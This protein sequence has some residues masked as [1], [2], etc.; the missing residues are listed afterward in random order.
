MS[1]EFLQARPQL[2]CSLYSIIARN[3]RYEDSMMLASE[4]SALSPAWRESTD[5]SAWFAPKDR[6]DSAPVCNRSR[7]CHFALFTIFLALLIVGGETALGQSAPKQYFSP[8]YG[9]ANGY[10]LDDTLASGVYLY[11]LSTE[12]N[13]KTFAAGKKVLMLK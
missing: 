3:R 13:G 12:K 5:D 2:I 11:R 4:R 10:Q 7:S 9:Y 1:V 8:F 6:V